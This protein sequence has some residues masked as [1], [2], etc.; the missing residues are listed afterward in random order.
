MTFLTDGGEVR[1]FPLRIADSPEERAQ[2]LMGVARLAE[3]DGMLFVFDEPT[4]NGFW[5]KQTLVPLD[6][7]FWDPTGRSTRSS[8]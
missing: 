1:A 3:D 8:R 2:G 5:M 6:V 4:G 7:A